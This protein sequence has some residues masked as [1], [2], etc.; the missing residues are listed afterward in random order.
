MT[1]KDLK[2]L[3]SSKKTCWKERWRADT[4]AGSY[5][6]SLYV[7]LVSM[8]GELLE[9]LRAQLQGQAAEINILDREGQAEA[10]PFEWA[11][12]MRGN[13]DELKP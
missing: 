5:C 3:Q 7:I 4:N 2:R 10:S 11:K 6:T 12:L 13:C 8:V 1:T 9:V